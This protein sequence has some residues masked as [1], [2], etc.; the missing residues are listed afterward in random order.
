MLIFS[1][2]STARSALVGAYYHP[3]FCR[4][5][6]DLT[7]IMIR[8]FKGYKTDDSIQ[9][10]KKTEQRRSTTTSERLPLKI[11]EDECSFN[12]QESTT[13]RELVED[14]VNSIT[15]IQQQQYCREHHLSPVASSDDF[16]L[17]FPSK[18]L[19]DSSSSVVIARTQ[20]RDNVSKNL[21]WC[22]MAILLIES[23]SFF[24]SHNTVIDQDDIQT[25]IVKTF[26][27][28]EKK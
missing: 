14:S 19:N 21:T 27:L 15:A 20:F 28:N 22:D 7:T 1:S 24:E 8:P 16:R 26:L 12:R 13:S 4:D 6:R 18:Q 11:D 3:L 23:P 9:Q 25:E 10:S 17:A 5:R 2:P